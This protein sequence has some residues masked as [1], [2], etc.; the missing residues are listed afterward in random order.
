[1]T[2]LTNKSR[3]LIH[4]YDQKR[5]EDEEPYPPEVTQEGI[6]DVLDIPRSHVTRVVRPLMEQGLIKESKGRVKGKGRKL[7]VY[8]IT[9]NGVSKIRERLGE[10]RDSSVEVFEE[11][12]SRK[13]KV[14][15]VI[16]EWDV[17]LLD[18]FDAMDGEGSLI[19]GDRLIVSNRA[20]GA[21]NFVNREEELMVAEDFLDSQ[22][23]VMS[24]ISNRGYGSSAFIKKVALDISDAPLGGTSRM[25][26]GCR[27]L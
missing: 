11:G 5:P 24:V 18:L 26:R 16:K 15:D 2:G 22:A 17:A 21:D 20:L 27:P 4:L 7:K 23:T 8:S 3:A 14:S 13:E 9:P 6:S 25:R 1:M 12:G 19:R 10:I